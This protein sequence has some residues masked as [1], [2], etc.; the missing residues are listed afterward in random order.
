MQRCRSPLASTANSGGAQTGLLF[1]PPNCNQ[2]G[3]TGSK[4]Q[5]GK[6]VV[7]TRSITLDQ[8]VKI[9]E[10]VGWEATVESDT[11]KLAWDV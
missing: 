8:M 1:L 9:L 3:R 2:T 10:M 7:Q 5:N 11:P 6:R 4:Q